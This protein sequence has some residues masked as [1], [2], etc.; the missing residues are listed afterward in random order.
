[1][2]ILVPTGRSGFSTAS[3]LERMR[4]PRLN[5]ADLYVA[6]FGGPRKAGRK[7]EFGHA[8][9]STMTVA[10]D[11]TDHLSRCSSSMSEGSLHDELVNPDPKPAKVPSQ[12]LEE[13]IDPATVH[14]S[15]PCY[16]CVAYMHSVG[17]RRVF[18]SI[19]G[20]EWESAKVRDLVDALDGNG[21]DATGSGCSM[22]VTK[23]EVLMMRRMMG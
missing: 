15:R 4:N 1:M 13:P 19:E 7:K 18:W 17:I 3:V 11:S 16:R 8:G 2:P 5:G 10:T 20:G 14:A 22:F 6:R 12:R 23:H 9:F 21:G